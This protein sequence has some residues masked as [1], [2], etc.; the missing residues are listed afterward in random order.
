[1]D[2]T[3]PVRLSSGHTINAEKHVKYLGLWLDRKLRWGKQLEEVKHK[4]EKSIGALASLGGSTWGMSFHTIRKIYLAVVI[5]QMSYGC[6]VWYSPPGEKRHNQGHTRTLQ[7]LQ[8]KAQKVIS[9]GFQATSIPALFVETFIPPIPLKLDQIACTTATQILCSTA[10][11]YIIGIRSTRKRREISPLEVLC[12]RIERK[13]GTQPKNLEKIRPYIMSPWWEPPRTH[14]ANTK[15]QAKSEHIESL[16]TLAPHLLRIYTDGSGINGKIGASAT[17]SQKTMSAYVGKSESYTVCYAELY[18]ILMTTS[19][20]HTIINI[21]RQPGITSTIIYTDNQAAIQKVKDPNNN[22]SGQ[23]L[24]QNVVTMIDGL[25]NTGADIELHW[26]PA[27]V[28]IAGNE[29]A[30]REAKRATGLRTVRK[31]NHKIVEVDTPYTAQQAY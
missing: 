23:H 14:L 25:R 16:K 15:L 27:H 28:D 5:P 7:S 2:T 30:D 4:V 21:E 29:R 1:M 18:G 20:T 19:L 22:K 3:Q 6:S 12:M 24:V 8:H 11:D 31:R 17:C 13:T 10:S 26:V 9:G